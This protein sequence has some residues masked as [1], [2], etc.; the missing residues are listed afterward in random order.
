MSAFRVIITPKPFRDFL[1]INSLVAVGVIL[2][3]VF[4]YKK[5]RGSKNEASD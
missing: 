1:M 5:S 2:L 4:G 3:G